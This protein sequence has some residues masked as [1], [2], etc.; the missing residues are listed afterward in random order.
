MTGSSFAATSWKTDDIVGKICET[1]N[2]DFCYDQQCTGGYKQ[3]TVAGVCDGKYNKH[4]LLFFTKIAEN[5]I[6]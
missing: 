4:S 6:Y 1:D 5:I 3:G 2:A